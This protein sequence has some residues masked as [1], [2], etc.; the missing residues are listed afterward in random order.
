MTI[1]FGNKPSVRVKTDR[2]SPVL[3]ILK[4]EGGI[5]LCGQRQFMSAGH[6][7]TGE[8]LCLQCLGA[9]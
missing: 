2:R 3:H 4:E 7:R 6:R 9:R 5:T 8:Y 1:V